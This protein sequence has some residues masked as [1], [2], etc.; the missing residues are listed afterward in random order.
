MDGGRQV[1]LDTAAL[2]GDGFR[3]LLR[4]LVDAIA[5]GNFVQEHTACEWCDFTAVCGPRPLLE[6]RRRYK[7]NDPRVQRVLRMRDVG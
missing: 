1:S 3:A 2:K 7:I 6:R 5:Q 4:G